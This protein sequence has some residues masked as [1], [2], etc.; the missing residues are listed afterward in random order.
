MNPNSKGADGQDREKKKNLRVTRADVAKYAGVSETI[1]SYVLNNNRYVAAEKRERVKKAVAELNY[2][3]NVIARALRKK[4]SRQILLITDIVI[5]EFFGENAPLVVAEIELP[6]EHADFPRPDWLG[7]EITSHG[8][9]TN[10]Y[11]SKHPYGSW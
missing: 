6:N 1:V 11:L 9:F 4:T 2:H 3:P 5:D 8:H 7:E 10:A